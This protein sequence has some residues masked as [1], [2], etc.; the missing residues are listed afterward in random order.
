MAEYRRLED[1]LVYQKLCRLHIEIGELTQRWPAEGR[2]ELGS[3]A[4]RSSNSAPVQFA[5]KYDDRHVRNRIEGVNRSR[6][7]A[8]ETV[9]H[10]YMAWRKATKHRKRTR[11]IVRDIRSASGCS[12]V[13]NVPLRGSCLSLT[14]A[15]PLRPCGRTPMPMVSV[16]AD[17]LNPEP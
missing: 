3:Q 17:I 9:H 13:W 15:G 8:S 14:A 4:R 5:E 16:P 1:L 12:T 10:L 11:S 2:F 7:E 6:G